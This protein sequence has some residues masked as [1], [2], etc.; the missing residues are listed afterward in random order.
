MLEDTI[1][2]EHFG[3][4]TDLA[5]GVSPA[6]TLLCVFNLPVPEQ[7]FELCRL[8]SIDYSLYWRLRWVILLFGEKL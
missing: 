2:T 6:H 3:S 5:L 8:S 7:G 4:L 1:L